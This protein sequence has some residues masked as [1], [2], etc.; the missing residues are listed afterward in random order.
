MSKLTN[1]FMVE[2]GCPARRRPPVSWTIYYNYRLVG[3][4]FT[5]AFTCFYRLVVRTKEQF[6]FVRRFTLKVTK[7]MFKV[8]KPKVTYP[9]NVSIAIV[10]WVL[11]KN[12]K[13]ITVYFYFWI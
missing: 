1:S 12:K 13:N 9:K 4:Q 5:Q 11:T 8:P 2:G 6:M 3:R 7:V 10:I